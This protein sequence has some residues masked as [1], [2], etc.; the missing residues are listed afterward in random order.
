MN[1]CSRLGVTSWHQVGE[2]RQLRELTVEAR[3][4]HEEDHLGNDQSLNPDIR[5]DD[6]VN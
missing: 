1:K 2:W 6:A 5:V 4:Y 3:I